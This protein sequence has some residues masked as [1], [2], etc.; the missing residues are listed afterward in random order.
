MVKTK[1]SLKD[2]ESMESFTR[3]VSEFD[4]NIYLRPEGD[5]EETKLDAKSIISVM[6]LVFYKRL[7]LVAQ[8]EDY[9]ELMMKLQPYIAQ[10]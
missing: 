8:T 4:Y 9:A 10:G 6:S 5:R 2:V 7:E 3:T 1:V